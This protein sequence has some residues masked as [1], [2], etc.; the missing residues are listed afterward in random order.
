MNIKERAQLQ[1]LINDA[2]KM[3]QRAFKE[4]NSVQF[5]KWMYRK[6][7][8]LDYAEMVGV[9]FK[10]I[11]SAYWRIEPRRKGATA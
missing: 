3:Q 5:D 8:L 10:L 9:Q 7:T 11:G 1:I 6:Q 2:Y 4:G